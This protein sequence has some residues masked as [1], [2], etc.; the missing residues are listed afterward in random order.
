MLINIKL[1]PTLKITKILS[2]IPKY[3]E[4]L[5][6][7]ILIACIIVIANLDINSNKFTCILFS[8]DGSI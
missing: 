5:F 4:L 6:P 7:N 2:S 1:M 8:S 3:L